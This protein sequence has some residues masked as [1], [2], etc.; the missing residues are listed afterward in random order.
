[1]N[2]IQGAVHFWMLDE[3]SIGGVQ[4]LLVFP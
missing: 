3:R 4:C 1:M 2:C